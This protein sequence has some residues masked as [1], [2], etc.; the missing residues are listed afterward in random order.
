[1]SEPW[2]TERKRQRAFGTYDVSTLRGVEIG[3]LDRPLVP[4]GSSEVY[5]VD[6]LSTDD[7][8]QKYAKDPGVSPLDI[9]PIDFVWRDQPLKALVGDKAP[10]DYV[11]ASH[12]IEHVPD[13]LGWLNEMAD[14]LKVG[15][16]LVL[17]V[18]DKRFTFDVMRRTSSIHD[19]LAAHQ[20]QRRRPGLRQILDYSIHVVNA[21]C[22][23]LWADY[24]QRNT[25]KFYHD[26]DFLI[27]TVGHFNEG[28]Y[29]D[30]HCWVFTPWSFFEILALAQD[31]ALVPFDLVHS[32]TTQENDLEFYVQLVKSDAPTTNWR[33]VARVAKR[34]ALHPHTSDNNEAEIAQV[35]APPTPSNEGLQPTPTTTQS[36]RSKARRILQ[37]LRN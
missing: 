24:S 10:L 19:V 35:P 33:E 7:L 3:P 5:F 2:V 1:M 29:I 4:P 23:S 16:R 17:V 30:V 26:Q 32:L 22:Y 21:D 27:R 8:R 9:V 6:H 13:L 31:Q 28:K 36:V 11:V 12:V 20:E 37:I 34:T 18:P 25:L 15:G 14:A